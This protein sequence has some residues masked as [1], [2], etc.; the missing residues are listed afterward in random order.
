MLHL[1]RN[2]PIKHKLMV[3][4][5]GI[6]GIALLI[7]CTAIALYE[8]GVFHRTL[9]RDSAILAHMFGENVASGLTFNDA[10]SIEVTLQAL[11]ANERIAGASVYNQHGVIT[12]TYRR[13]GP[14]GGNFAF[15]AAAPAGQHFGPGRLDTFQDITLAGEVIGSL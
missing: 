13:P 10:A 2:L 5:M 6:S 7:A 11:S 12:A 4:T 14:A 8:Q 15:P 3:L 1:F 9:A